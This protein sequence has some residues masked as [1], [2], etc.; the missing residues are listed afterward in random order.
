MEITRIQPFDRR[1]V[2]AACMGI[3][4]LL[5]LLVGR[6]GPGWLDQPQQVHCMVGFPGP[7]GSKT[8]W[9]QWNALPDCPG[10]KLINI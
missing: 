7:D 5:G 1:G 6:L 3:A 8:A 4:M 2:A 10:G 9:K